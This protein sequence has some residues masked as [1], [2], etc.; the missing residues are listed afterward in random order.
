MS[1]LKLLHKI[2]VNGTQLMLLPNMF[3]VKLWILSFS[4]VMI[5]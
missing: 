5:K 1:L 3:K 4:Q 2:Q